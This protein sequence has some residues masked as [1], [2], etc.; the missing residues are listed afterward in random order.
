MLAFGLVIAAHNTP[1]YLRSPVIAAAGC[2]APN[3]QA[4]PAPVPPKLEKR[5][6]STVKP[7]D[8]FPTDVLEKERLEK[9]L[10][11]PPDDD[12]LM[13]FDEE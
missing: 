9:G 8:I 1:P 11:A 12:E 4:E 10:P 13:I 7:E 6:A 2:T 5:R 3:K